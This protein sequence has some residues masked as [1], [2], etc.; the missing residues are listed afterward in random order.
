MIRPSCPSFLLAKLPL[1][2]DVSRGKARLLGE[3]DVVGFDEVKAPKPMFRR[4][5]L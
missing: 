4:V 2:S 5:L 1:P 3:E